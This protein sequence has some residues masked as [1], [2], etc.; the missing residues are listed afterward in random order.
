MQV[1]TKVTIKTLSETT[2]GELVYVETANEGRSLAIILYVPETGMARVGC[3]APV[4]GVSAVPTHIGR[5]ISEACISFGLDWVLEPL[6]DAS[7]HLVSKYRDVPG[8]VHL[9]ERVG[10]LLCSFPRRAKR[11]RN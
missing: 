10:N 4:I 1:A 7:F 2:P 5:P 6:M 3:L 9:S 11:F 8:V